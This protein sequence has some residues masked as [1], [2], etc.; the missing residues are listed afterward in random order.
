[1]TVKM[2]KY[3]R[4]SQGGYNGKAPVIVSREQ[5]EWQGTVSESIEG[6]LK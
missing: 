3:D 4:G 1:M 6:I 5:R 2:A